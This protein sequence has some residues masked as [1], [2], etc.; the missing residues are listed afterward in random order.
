MPLRWERFDTGEAN[1]PSHRVL[2][3]DVSPAGE[4]WAGTDRGAARFDGERWQTFTAADSGLADDRVTAVEAGESAVWFGTPS[5]L[6]RLETATG[7]WQTTAAGRDGF[8]AAAIGDLE[9]AS[10]GVLWAGT[11]GGGLG[12]WDGSAWRSYVTSNSDL[13]LNTVQKLYATSGGDLWAG[14]AFAAQPSGLIARLSDGK[15]TT[16]GL[17]HSGYSGAEPLS[18]GEDVFGRLWIGTRNGG[19]ELYNPAR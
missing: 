14:L 13:P 2:A 6:S 16:Y 18:F 5:G 4:V 10:D 9:L 12:A 3:L 7:A 11:M 8:G 17:R 19:I 15:W 1:L